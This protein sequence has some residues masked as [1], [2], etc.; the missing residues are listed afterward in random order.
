MH[1]LTTLCVLL[2]IIYWFY[3]LIRA[4]YN[5]L[6]YFNIRAFYAQ[7]LDIKPVEKKR[8]LNPKNFILKLYI[9]E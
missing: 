3:R 2:S 9:V 7:A 5:L 8:K 1:L 4:L 6:S